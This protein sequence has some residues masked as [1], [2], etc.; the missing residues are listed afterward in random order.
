MLYVANVG[1]GEPLEPPPR[2]VAEH[3]ERRGARA[4]AVSARIEAELSE[5]DDDE[6][7]AMREELGVGGVR[8]C[9]R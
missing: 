1:E 8:A 2:L 3:A 5:L 9:D 7:A 4:A 6:A